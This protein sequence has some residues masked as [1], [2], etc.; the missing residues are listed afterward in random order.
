MGGKVLLRAEM[1]VT[2]RT[3]EAADCLVD[4]RLVPPKVILFGERTAAV[5]AV[6]WLGRSGTQGRG[7]LCSG[8]A[9]GRGRSGRR[10]SKTSSRRISV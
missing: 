10:G 3:G 7:L 9:L 1:E 6:M 5:G 2:M 4:Q 8:G